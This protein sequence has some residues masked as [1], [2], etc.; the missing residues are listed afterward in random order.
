MG[1][2]LSV[3]ERGY[4]LAKVFQSI[5]LYFAHW[6]D[7][8]IGKDELDAAFRA[9]ADEALPCDERRR[10]SLLLTAFMAKLNNGHT[11]FR[12]PYLVE[13][14]PVGMAL[15]PVDERW[16]VVASDLP[17]LRV[18]DVIR[19]IE[20]EPIEAWYDE[21]YPYTVGSPQSRTVQ[22]G[23]LK[24]FFPPL[25]RV[26]LPE[27]YTVAFEDARGATRT[28]EVDRAALDREAVPLR[29]E[30]RWL[31]EGL[32]YIKV[33]SFLDPE[34]EQR[35]L[36]YV[37]EFA[38]AAC[39]IVDVRSNEGGSTPGA[40][41]QALMDRPY[42]WWI[43]SSPLNVG[44]L[45]YDAQRGHN[46]YLF[47]DSHLRWRAPATDPDPEG[48][49]GRLILL[50]DR[51]TWSA[52][53]DFVMPFLDNRRATVIGEM[54]GGS[55]GQPYYHM[56][57]NGMG[58]AVGTKRVYLPDGGRFEGVGL[59]PDI[60]VQVQREDLYAGRDPVLERAIAVA[61]GQEAKG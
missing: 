2:A 7:A 27:R 52:G 47:G 60:A 49:A 41:T 57:D 32:A 25:I 55:T 37:H 3:E 31:E 56:F 44:L 30:G 45:A 28:L 21:L 59:A 46:A 40:L 4:I 58:F 17:Q 9:L 38:G 15:R 34:F 33:P 29:T 54:T 18:G 12:D 35:A 61:R 22:F 51:A 23:D 43:E 8:T 39:M 36:A 20:D 1:N 14:P 42:R 26:F 10:F 16:T 48:Y 6:E 13:A 19:R 5:P 11:R 50:V 24:G 53:E